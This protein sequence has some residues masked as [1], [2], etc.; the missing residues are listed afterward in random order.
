[1]SEVEQVNL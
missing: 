1:M